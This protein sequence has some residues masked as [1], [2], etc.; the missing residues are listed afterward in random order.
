[1]NPILTILLNPIARKVHHARAAATSAVSFSR[2][3]PTTDQRKTAFLCPKTA[4]DGV[5][6]GR[7]SRLPVSLAG[8]LTPHAAIWNSSQSADNL[9]EVQ[10]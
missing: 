1:M 2:L 7:R 3:K 10:P 9:Q 5:G 4:P 6:V 8:L